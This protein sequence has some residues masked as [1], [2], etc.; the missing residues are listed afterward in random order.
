ME[1]HPFTCFRNNRP[2]H[3]NNAKL[4]YILKIFYVPTHFFLSSY[5]YVL[6]TFIIRYSTH[7]RICILRSTQTHFV[8]PRSKWNEAFFNM[9][10]EAW[11][12][13]KVIL[14]NCTKYSTFYIFLHFFCFVASPYHFFHIEWLLRVNIYIL[15]GIFSLK[16][17]NNIFQNIRQNNIFITVRSKS[18]FIQ[19]MY[20]YYSTRQDTADVVGTCVVYPKL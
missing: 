16:E 1:L 12:Y 19:A 15:Y 17:E 14:L 9:I 6:P 13:T 18:D 7:I 4:T 8:T 10:R 11:Y 3:N 2:F 5:I 20:F